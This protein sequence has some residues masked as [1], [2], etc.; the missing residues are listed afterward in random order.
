MKRVLLHSL[1]ILVGLGCMSSIGLA[2]KSG[3]QVGA[4]KR[5]NQTRQR[6]KTC[7][8]TPAPSTI[9]ETVDGMVTIRVSPRALVMGAPIPSMTVHADIPRADVDRESVRLNGFIIPTRVFADDCGDLVVKFR[10]TEV[11]ELVENG[12]SEITLIL[13]GETVSDDLLIEFEPFIGESTIPVRKIG[14]RC[15]TG[16]A[17]TPRRR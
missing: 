5:Q 16:P 17:G 8:P 1:A 7:A 14:K 13:T 10:F 6:P 12:Q 2:G 11:E 9:G 3:C 4:D 15:P